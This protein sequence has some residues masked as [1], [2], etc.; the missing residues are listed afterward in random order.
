MDNR[1]KTD[2]QQQFNP[3]VSIEQA[4]DSLAPEVKER[5]KTFDFSPNLELIPPVEG[6]A[7]SGTF[8]PSRNFSDDLCY[9][10]GFT[11]LA[12]LAGGAAWGAFEGSRMQLQTNSLSVRYSQMLTKMTTKGPYFGN[13]FGSLVTVYNIGRFSFSEL[14]LGNTN[15]TILGA[16][17][18]G[19]I[20]R[21]PRGSAAAIRGAGFCGL[22]SLGWLFINRLNKPED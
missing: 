21:A 5:L 8:V 20:V 11:Y 1:A 16:I 15:A 22:A 6:E 12:G 19:L 17:T 18:S 2:V 13:L 7:K 3:A 14:G 4:F 9:G 10:V